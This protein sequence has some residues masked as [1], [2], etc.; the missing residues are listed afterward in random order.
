MA[1]G[2]KLSTRLQSVPEALSAGPILDR[3]NRWFTLIAAD[4]VELKRECFRL[5]YQVYCV[6]NRFEN[7]AEHPDGLESDAFDERA[8]HHL[9]VHHSTGA[10]V[11]TVRLVLPARA[12]GRLELPIGQVCDEEYLV[13][14]IGMPV[15]STAEISRFAVSK[16]FR[17]RVTDA[18]VVDGGF[19]GLARNGDLSARR[20]L[21]HITFGLMRAV[22]KMSVDNGITHL[23]A[24]MEP[25]LL[26]LVGRV[27]FEFTPIG[28]L[29]DYHGIRQPCFATN[30]DLGKG[31]IAR[32]PDVMKTVSERGKY[33]QPSPRPRP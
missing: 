30:H 12:R 4:T 28:P 2:N 23:V 22:A 17:R 32:R 7:P 26:R 11:G 29:V 15:D 24:V 13:D 18:E 8:V 1:L 33:W 14:T 10:V 3:Y 9:L 31:L 20:V 16:T 27:G 25:A 5:R 19:Q 6:E 21:P